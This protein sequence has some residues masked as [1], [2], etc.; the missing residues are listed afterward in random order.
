MRRKCWERRGCVSWDD[1]RVGGRRDRTV[2]RFILLLLII[3]VAVRWSMRVVRTTGATRTR[4]SV[5]VVVLRLGVGS[6]GS[7]SLN[8]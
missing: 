3:V 2:A 8:C 7:S 5:L 1:R 4:G 6:S